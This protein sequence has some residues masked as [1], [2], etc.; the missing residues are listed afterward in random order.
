MSP[1]TS[2]FISRQKP[3]QEV[4]WNM[5]AHPTASKL[6]IGGINSADPE[7]KNL[8]VVDLT[9]YPDYDNF[10][11]SYAGVLLS[12][13]PLSVG[14]QSSVFSLA[15]GA[16]FNKLYTLVYEQ[17]KY[18]G[19]ATAYFSIYNLDTNGD[20]TGNVKS[21]PLSKTGNLVDKTDVNQSDTL[22]LHPSL[23]LIYV[24]DGQDILVYDLD[25]NNYPIIAGAKKFNIVKDR[26]YCLAIHDNGKKLYAGHSKDGFVVA[27]L[28]AR[29]CWIYSRITQK[30]ILN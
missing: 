6:Y 7:R 3:T 25:A 19:I 5:V 1:Q 26:M 12:N 14:K 16:K 4:I 29:C 9:S 18:G 10:Q 8:N 21:Y 28:N 11:K 27:T 23:P 17:A 30:S 22:V 15:I 2:Y 20:I 24:T 13:F